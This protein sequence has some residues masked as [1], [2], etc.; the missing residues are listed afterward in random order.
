MPRT[1]H[2]QQDAVV[3]LEGE[4]PKYIYILQSGLVEIGR[5]DPE[6]RK[7]VYEP[8]KPGNFFGIENKILNL[9]YM[10]RAISKSA[11]S[12]VLL[13][14]EEFEQFVVRDPNLSMNITKNLCTELKHTHAR[15]YTDIQQIEKNHERGMCHVAKGFFST[16]E[17]LPCRSVSKRFL[18][19]YP[20]SEFKPQVEELVKET[21]KYTLA[22]TGFLSHVLYPNTEESEIFLQ[23][24]F[25]RYEKEYEPREVIFSEFEK[26]DSVF[27]VLSG[28]VRSTKYIK[29]A[30]INLS[31]ARP[32]EFFGL[33]WFVDMEYRDV[34]AITTD[35]VK[36]LEFKRDVFM[37]LLAK[38]P[39]ISYMFIKSLSYKVHVDRRIFRNNFISNLQTRLKDMFSVLD[40]IGFCEK[41]G[42]KS[43]KIYL[44]NRN[45]S[46]WTS[47]PLSE[48]EKEME[49]LETQGI[50]KMSDEGWF[51]VNDIEEARRV[52]QG[53]RIV[54]NKN[55]PL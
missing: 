51:I 5:I 30:N 55:R 45:I 36:L 14:V 21:E 40:E 43:R 49:L 37:E 17:F 27:M 28:V 7:V 9:P 4:N 3:F 6:T 44:T 10:M 34:S 22:S 38:N 53:I 8:V 32:G 11:S 54:V 25:K 52:S 18:E 33:N 41:V 31:L 20:N 23:D 24:S 26:E 1:V 50:V 2:Y 39:V 19:L 29:G 35:T 16:E 13:T 42:G 12:V 15:M 48:I 46:V 47:V